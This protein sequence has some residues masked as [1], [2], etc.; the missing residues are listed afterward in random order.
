[1]RKG[2]KKM[3]DEDEGTTVTYNG[4]QDENTQVNSVGKKSI[5]KIK[6]SRKSKKSRIL[7]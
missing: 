5:K 1:M 6:K 3:F 2:V 4:N 7:K